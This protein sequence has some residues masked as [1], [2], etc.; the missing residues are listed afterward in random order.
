MRT[1][2]KKIV[3]LVALFS[4][5]FLACSENTSINIPE[6]NKTDNL[7]KFKA[8]FS[9]HLMKTE[10][11]QSINGE[12]GGTIDINFTSSDGE[13][14]VVGTLVFPA[15]SFS[16]TE[17]I[18]VSVAGDLAALDFGPSMTF[19]NAAQLNLSIT[20]VNVTADDNV[21]FKYI[22]GD[23]S[24]SSVDYADISVS[25]DDALV[26][27]QDAELNHFSRYGWTK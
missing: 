21:D 9:H 11:S 4:L 23:G 18:S 17:D 24:L 10:V 16:G 26:S 22:H 6:S 7:L 14:S 20:G 13:F 25:V 19:Q 1:K 12:T 5:I 27:V 15:N 2:M 8:N 3:I